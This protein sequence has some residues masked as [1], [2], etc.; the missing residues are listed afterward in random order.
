MKPPSY[1]TIMSV[2]VTT[3]GSIGKVSSDEKLILIGIMGT[4]TMPI[5]MI[6]TQINAESV[7]TLNVHIAKK[8]IKAQP[9]Q[10]IR[11]I[12]R[13][14]FVLWMIAPDVNDEIKPTKT[15]HPH[16]KEVYPVPKSVEPKIVPMTEPKPM[17][18]PSMQKKAT[19]EYK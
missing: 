14:F 11:I 17:K 10:L 8:A 2:P 7:A 15:Q 13:N 3:V 9:K 19:S 12:S 16:S 18:L 4:I 1:P 6:L 5:E